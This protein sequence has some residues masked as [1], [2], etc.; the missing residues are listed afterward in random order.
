MLVQGHEISAPVSKN[1]AQPNVTS[2]HKLRILPKQCDSPEV[3]IT[4]SEDQGVKR[5]RHS[6]EVPNVTAKIKV[7]GLDQGT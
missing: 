6:I 3:I 4:N 7:V 2:Q 1:Y 5:S